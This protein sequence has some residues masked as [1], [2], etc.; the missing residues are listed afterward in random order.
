MSK[1]DIVARNYVKQSSIF[2]DV[3]NFY[4]YGGRQVI[5]PEQLR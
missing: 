1:A 2:A 3:F 5:K 4:L